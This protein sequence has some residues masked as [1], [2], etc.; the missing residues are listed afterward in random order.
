[1]SARRRGGSERTGKEEK[2]RMSL[3]LDLNRVVD[4]EGWKYRLKRGLDSYL[5]DIDNE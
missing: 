1:M 2:R 3:A 5:R 4:R